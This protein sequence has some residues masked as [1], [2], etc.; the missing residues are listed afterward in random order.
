MI[1]FMS[2][3]AASFIMFDD[4]AKAVLEA[5]GDDW[6]YP[7]IWRV[8]RLAEILQTLTAV[9]AAS[10]QRAQQ[11]ERTAWTQAIEDGAE[12]GV[13]PVGFSDSCRSWRC[14]RRPRRPASPLSGSAKGP[15]A[16]LLR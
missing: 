16:G 12:P 15:N 5:A 4:H 3:A 7:G 1:R 8:E 10:A 2:K 11:A 13:F 14:C 6:A 9:S